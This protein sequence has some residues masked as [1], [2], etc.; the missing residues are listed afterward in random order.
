MS[1]RRRVRRALR[2]SKACLLIVALSWNQ[3]V[4]T[5]LMAC[6]DASDI[7]ADIDCPAHGDMH[8][9]ASH[10]A[11]EPPSSGARLQ[12]ADACESRALSVLS[13][14]APVPDRIGTLVTAAGVLAAVHDDS[15]PRGLGPAPGVPPP[16]S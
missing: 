8:Q 16:R 7:E 12:C 13:V 15:D 11:D 10:S 6:M 4:A 1:S 9:H 3:L 14:S 5:P 2:L